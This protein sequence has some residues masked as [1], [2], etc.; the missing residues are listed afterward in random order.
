[1]EPVVH[2]K[3]YE[4][5]DDTFNNK[6]DSSAPHSPK[7]VVLGPMIIR[8]ITANFSQEFG[9][10]NKKDHSILFGFGPYGDG[11]LSLNLFGFSGTF[12]SGRIGGNRGIAI[13]GKVKWFFGKI[14]Y[15]NDRIL[16]DG[17]GINIIVILD[18]LV[19]KEN[20][21]LI[22]SEDAYVD[23]LHSN[24]NYGTKETL[25][26]TN[27]NGSDTGRSYL[28]FNL[29][30]IPNDVTI[31]YALLSIFYCEYEGDGEP[32]IGVY[33]VNNNWDEDNINWENQPEISTKCEYSFLLP[34]TD[35][36]EINWIDIS[37]L[38]QSWLNNDNPNHG[39]VLKFRNP[40]QN[41]I[42][43]RV[44]KS[45]EWD[46]EQEKPTLFIKYY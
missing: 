36:I 18:Y 26:V 32:E 29:S 16:I 27:H 44:F 24:Q 5:I 6:I 38:V 2:N 35:P 39:I 46:V 3:I 8:R 45:K 33:R 37:D 11:S 15:V 9:I 20:L 31:F 22:S 40:Y 13:Y 17:W 30:S 21:V 7:G 12:D 10:V 28:K 41:D 43:N 14:E 25:K 23:G 42:T 1:L 19:V 34:I 4:E